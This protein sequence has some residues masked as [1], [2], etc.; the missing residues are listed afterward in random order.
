MTFGHETTGGQPV[1]CDAE[2]LIDH[3]APDDIEPAGERMFT[4][5]REAIG[6]G[7]GGQLSQ[8]VNAI[9]QMVPQGRLHAVAKD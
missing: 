4:D 7:R 2:A 6:L 1:Y 3:I 8:Q 5:F 9:L